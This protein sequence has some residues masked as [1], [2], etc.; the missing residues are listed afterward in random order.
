M[1]VKPAAAWW[2]DPDDPLQ[3]RYWDGDGWTTHV[4]SAESPDGLWRFNGYHWVPRAV[5]LRPPL[6]G[7][8][9]TWRVIWLI[10]WGAWLPVAVA[11]LE[12]IQ[13]A[14]NESTAVWI[15]MVPTCL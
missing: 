1:S 12:I 9:R 15:L 14:S 11:L 13:P 10:M 2:P 6:P 4:T 5:R 7:S 3:L 8:L